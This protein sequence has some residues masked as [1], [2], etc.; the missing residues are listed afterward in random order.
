MSHR[1]A[2]L[3][4]RSRL[5]LAQ[6]VVHQCWS[7]RRAAEHFQVSVPTAA[8][9]AQR[10]REHGPEAMED[11]SNRP[12]SSPRRTATRTERRSTGVRVNPPVGVGEISY[13]LV[14]HHS[15]VDRVLSRYRLA[16][17]TGLGRG[18]GRLKQ[19]Q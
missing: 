2:L 15:T 4:P 7:L 12:H 19:Y 17:V 11:R 5:Q 8:P 10:Y 14:I 18:T 9:W 6:C 13:L 16:D 3:T 1:N